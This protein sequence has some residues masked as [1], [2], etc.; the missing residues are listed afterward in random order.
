MSLL[1]A[2]RGVD[3]IAALVEATVTPYLIH[4]LRDAMLSSSTGRRILKDRPRINSTT[5]SLEW[6]RNL[7]DVT[8]GREYAA[9]GEYREWIANEERVRCVDDP[10]CA[11]VM[12]RYRECHN[13]YHAL[14]G[15][16]VIAE[17][18][19]VL[20]ACE[21]ANTLLPRTGLSMFAVVG[22]GPWEG[23]EG[24]NQLLSLRY[25]KWIAGQGSDQHLLGRG[26]GDRCEGAEEENRLAEAS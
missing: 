11:Y 17:G 9:G 24:P 1:N 26:V 22:L 13:F 3:L 12:Q 20:K 19:V 10:E 18:E 25:Q 5:V 16:P 23:G 14:T 6:L 4:R 21:F 2:R 7:P 15:L 8:M